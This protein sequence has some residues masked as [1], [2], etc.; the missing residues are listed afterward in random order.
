MV[1]AK[2]LIIPWF[3]LLPPYSQPRSPLGQATERNTDFL[4]DLVRAGVKKSQT[5]IVMCSIGG[6]LETETRRQKRP[7]FEQVRGSGTHSALRRLQPRSGVAVHA[8][9]VDVEAGR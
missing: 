1:V 3:L 8:L 6:S 5:I 2:P 7:D 9:L 4:D